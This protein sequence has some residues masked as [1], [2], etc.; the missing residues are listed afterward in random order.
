MHDVP[1]VREW[2]QIF[3]INRSVLPVYDG[4]EEKARQYRSLIS[5]VNKQDIHIVHSFFI[6]YTI[7]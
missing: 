3:R 2:G 5:I 1:A 4:P 6:K 7:F